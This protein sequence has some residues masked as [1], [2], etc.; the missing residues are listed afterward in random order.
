MFLQISGFFCKSRDFFHG[1]KND[2]GLRLFIIHTNNLRVK[3]IK[4]LRKYTLDDVILG[5]ETVFYPYPSRWQSL[6]RGCCVD[7]V[8]LGLETVFYPYSSRWQSLVRGCR[9]GSTRQSVG[10]GLAGQA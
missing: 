7:D 2:Y 4:T 1:S 10:A 5:L 6:V 9:V 3:G 8:I